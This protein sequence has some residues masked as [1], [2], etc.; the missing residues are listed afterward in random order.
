MTLTRW[1][2]FD[3]LTPLREAMNQLLE[4]SFIRPM[5][6]G[7]GGRVFP[8]DVYETETEYVIEAV[9][10]GIKPEDLKITAAGSMVTIQAP[11]LATPKAATGQP[12]QRKYLQRERY[13]GEMTRTIELPTET[14]PDKI[15]ATYEQGVLTLR[16]P[17]VEAAKPIQ[18]PVRVQAPMAA[19]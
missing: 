14:D 15:E 3:G 9:V 6:S 18:I 17:K 8:L 5:H 12:A 19:Q 10:P 1:E 7:L 11:I 13:V 4:D 2:P 16:L